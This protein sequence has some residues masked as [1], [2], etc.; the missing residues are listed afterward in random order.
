MI[1]NSTNTRWFS[2][3][4]LMIILTTVQGLAQESRFGTYYQQRKTLFEKLPNTKKEIIF[5]GNS[6]TDGCEWSELLQNKRVKNRGI[7]GDITEGVLHRLAEVTESKPAKVFLLIGVNDL[8]RGISNDTIFSNI[9]RIA[10]LINEQSPKT[11]VY[12]QSILPVN[13]DFGKFTGHCSKTD[14]ILWINEQLVKWCEHEPAEFID[15]FSHFRNTTDNLMNPSYTND[16]LHL[17]GEGYLLWA[18]II[19]PYLK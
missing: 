9:C 5:L 2:M 7:S 13:P 14:D 17:T 10:Q 19:K 6:I 18:K 1:R 15:L 16:G 12:I 4:G 3:L 11:K 8:A